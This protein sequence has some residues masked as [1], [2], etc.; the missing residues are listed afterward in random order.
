MTVSVV[1]RVPRLQV[2]PPAAACVVPR[3]ASGRQPVEHQCELETQ[4]GCSSGSRATSCSG[5]LMGARMERQRHS[6][7]RL[8]FQR[9]WFGLFPPG[10]LASKQAAYSRRAGGSA[11]TPG[12]RRRRFAVLA[13]HPRARLPA[14]TMLRRTVRCR[15]PAPEGR[16][17]LRRQP[18]RCSQCCHRTSSVWFLRRRLRSGRVSRSD[19]PLCHG[20][21]AQPLAVCLSGR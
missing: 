17:K 15:S 19:C 5:Y 14:R 20:A 1:P 9:R 3:P 16:R 6:H 12:S 8:V 2:V 18:R 7:P 21:T 10:P 4:S 11:R 13:G